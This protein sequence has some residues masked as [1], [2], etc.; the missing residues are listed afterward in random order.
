MLSLIRWCEAQGLRKCD[1]NRTSKSCVNG[2]NFGPF[3]TGDLCEA[4]NC[5]D[6][7]YTFKKGLA[8]DTSSDRVLYGSSALSVLGAVVAS[9]NDSAVL[10]IDVLA[11]DVFADDAPPTYLYYN[12]TKTPL[13][14]A[15]E[16]EACVAR[17]PRDM[18][19]AAN[20][21]LLQAGVDCSGAKAQAELGVASVKLPPDTA[22]LVSLPDKARSD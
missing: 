14:V 18:I 4:L 9:T 20:G 12:P 10:R 22:V 16:S 11:T 7:T 21:V 6:I 5:T 13:F 8:C 1:Y 2:E 15:V 17:R 19:S 3:A